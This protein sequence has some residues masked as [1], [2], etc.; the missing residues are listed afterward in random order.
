M[1]AAFHERKIPCTNSTV[2]R[3]DPLP[4]T[5]EDSR[6]YDRKLEGSIKSLDSVATLKELVSSIYLSCHSRLNCNSLT[7]A[8][9]AFQCTLKGFS[10]A[11]KVDPSL[12]KSSDD[13]KEE[14]AQV[15]ISYAQKMPYMICYDLK[16]PLL[17]PCLR[18]V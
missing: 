5:S 6:F 18:I 1:P 9:S 4:N 15:T 3:S 10:V 14:Y 8:A 13:K 7:W 2:S 11:F 12:P 16:Y 17:P